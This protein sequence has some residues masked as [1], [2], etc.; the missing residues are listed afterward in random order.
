MSVRVDA[1]T[2][3][4]IPIFQNCDVVPLQI[5]AFASERMTVGIG[6]NLL[7]QGRATDSAYLV[8]NGTFRLTANGIEVGQAEPGSFLGETAM[9]GGTL[10]SIT[11]VA[12]DLSYVARISHGTF[13]KVAQEYPEFGEMVL[14]SLNRRVQT[15]LVE[16]EA[17]R[18]LMLSAKSFS[19]L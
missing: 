10:S 4:R 7:E 16:L 17:V 13:I 8:L 6:E 12:N 15:T 14:R 3:R 1:E 2:L 9:I 5:L 18:E 19:D 11:A